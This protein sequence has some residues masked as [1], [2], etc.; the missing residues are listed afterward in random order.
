MVVKETSYKDFFFDKS[1]MLDREIRE[2]KLFENFSQKLIKI[3]SFS[4]GWNKIL[5]GV[6]LSVITERN[7][8]KML[9]ITKKSSLPLIQKN[10]LPYG[11]LSI[12]PHNQFPLIFASPGPIY[13]PGD[14]DDFWNMSRS[15]YAAGLRKNDV[16]YNTFSYHL[17]PA[18][19]MMHQACNNI[20]STVIP[21]G[22]GN[23]ELQL[24]TIRNLQ[25]TFYLGTPS[26]LKILLEKAKSNNID[27]SSLT[28]GL[29]GAEPLPTSLRKYL[30]KQGVEVMQMYGIAE[31][32]CIAYETKDKNKNLINGMLIEEDIIL[33]I[34][35]PGTSQSLPPGEVGE[36]VVTKVNSDYPMI[37]LGTGDLSKIIDEP[38]PCGR[39]NYRIEGW[40]GR[41]EQSTKFKGLFVTPSQV[42]KIIEVFKD[43]CKVK[44]II[45]TK[46]FLDYGELLC[47]T[48]NKDL[49]LQNKVKEYF[50]SN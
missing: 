40:M 4:L 42:N 49:D 35:R 12:K 29:V 19:I 18:G 24:E 37:R 13:E 30:A 10:S 9:P 48:A 46:D 36:V 38:S 1:E 31:V 28:N 6:D 2:E 20:G 14:K 33:E 43:I 47:E 8:L 27:I 39:T 45:T 22:V 41:A 25:P 23:T 15:L 7:S 21:G 3:A 26:F 17:G 44:L 50:K 32:G 16:V 34:V 5:E 11:N